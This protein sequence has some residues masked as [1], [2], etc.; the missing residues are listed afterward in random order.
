MCTTCVPNVNFL[1]TEMGSNHVT[2]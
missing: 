1:H 2:W